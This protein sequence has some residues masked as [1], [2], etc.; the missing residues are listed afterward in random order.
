MQ[1][2]AVVGEDAFA[3]LLKSRTVPYSYRYDFEREKREVLYVEDLGGFRMQIEDEKLTLAQK[4][5]YLLTF[6]KK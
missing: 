1:N 2:D 6:S 3:A 5:G 4:D